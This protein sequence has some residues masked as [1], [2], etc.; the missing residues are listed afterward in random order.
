VGGDGSGAYELLGLDE[1]QFR[2]EEGG[3][4]E[5]EFIAFRTRYSEES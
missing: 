5:M 4:V 2:S 3:A 1:M